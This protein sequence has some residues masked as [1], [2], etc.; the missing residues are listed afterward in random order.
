MLT[1][2]GALLQKISRAE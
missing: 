1:R 2:G